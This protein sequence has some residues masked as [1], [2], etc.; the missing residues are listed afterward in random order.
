MLR[1][2]GSSSFRCRV[3]AS[4]LC[5]KPLRIDRI[6]E[7]DDHPGLHEAE[8]A[9]IQSRVHHLPPARAGARKN[10]HRGAKGR[11]QAGNVVRHRDRHPRGRTVG[12]PRQMAQAA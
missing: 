1:F 10:R 12:I 4:I 11:V 7:K 2:E 5:S 3:V 6:R 9:L 8:G